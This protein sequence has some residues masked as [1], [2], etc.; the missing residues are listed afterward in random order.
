MQENEEIIELAKAYSAKV[1]STNKLWIGCAT[2]SLLIWSAIG[3]SG[4][5][6]LST[7]FGDFPAATL[8]VV[9]GFALSFTFW[10]FSV[11]AINLMNT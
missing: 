7:I 1:K 8:V 9:L 3:V 4:S 5:E 11:A 6:K 2:L 10:A